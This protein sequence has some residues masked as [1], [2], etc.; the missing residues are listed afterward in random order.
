MLLYALRTG[1]ELPD[2][3]EGLHNRMARAAGS[4]GA[5]GEFFA[6]AK[7]K[8]YTMARIKRAAMQAMLGIKAEDITLMRSKKPIYARL[9][10]YS[11]RAGGLIGE[12]ARRA[13]IPFAARASEFR[14]DTPAMARLWQIDQIASDV[15]ALAIHNPALRQGK[16]DLTEKMIVL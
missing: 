10:G 13:R 1:R 2:E 8:R 6:E 5:I 3:A 12:L 4:A 7:S 11:R 14:P 15:Y 9:L 16:R